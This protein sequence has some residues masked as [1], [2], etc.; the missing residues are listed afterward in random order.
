MIET[1]AFEMADMEESIAAKVVAFVKHGS[2]ILFWLV[3]DGVAFLVGTL[4]DGVS[5]LQEFCVAPVGDASKAADDDQGPSHIAHVREDQSHDNEEQNPGLR[6]TVD[7]G[8]YRQ[9]F[10]V[11]CGD[12]ILWRF[13]PKFLNPP[14]TVDDAYGFGGGPF[15]S[16]GVS[17]ETILGPYNCHVGR[18]LTKWYAVTYRRAQ[19]IYRTWAKTHRLVDHVRCAKH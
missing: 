17:A 13:V 15:D 11:D 12:P 7:R 10:R 18:P 16:S 9:G 2:C 4:A 8:F 5:K 6:L 1:Q 3:V 14:V 19:G